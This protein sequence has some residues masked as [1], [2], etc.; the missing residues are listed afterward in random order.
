MNRR[1][2]LKTTTI[3]VTGLI[4]IAPTSNAIPNSDEEKLE[5]ILNNA[6]IAFDEYTTKYGF[7]NHETVF[8]Y[9]RMIAGIPLGSPEHK[10][11][12][13][14]RERAII[15][16]NDFSNTRKFIVEKIES[17]SYNV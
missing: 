1:E 5:Q 14:A 10:W 6:W 9:C 2:F 13:Q 7:S 12:T 4:L 17:I 11:F 3:G 8:E 15:H 16:R